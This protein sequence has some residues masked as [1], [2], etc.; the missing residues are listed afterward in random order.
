MI[1]QKLYLLHLILKHHNYFKV[2]GESCIISGDNNDEYTVDTRAIKAVCTE[3]NGK[4][5]ELREGLKGHAFT[6]S[7]RDEMGEHDWQEFSQKM[8]DGDYDVPCSR[9]KGQNVIDAPDLHIVTDCQ[10]KKLLKFFEE[11][12]A[13]ASAAYWESEGERRMGC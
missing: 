2:K 9:C 10:V 4:G 1:E 7:E 8:V 11:L 13:E 5:T 3:C 6:E 12:E